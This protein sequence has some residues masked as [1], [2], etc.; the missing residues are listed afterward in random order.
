MDANTG[1]AIGNDISQGQDIARAMCYG[2]TY[3]IHVDVSFKLGDQPLPVE[4]VIFNGWQANELD[5]RENYQGHLIKLHEEIRTAN[6]E[7]CIP[8]DENPAPCGTDGS[9]IIQNDVL[10]G[11]SNEIDLGELTPEQQARYG[12]ISE[13]FAQLQTEQTSEGGDFYGG[14]FS[15]R[16]WFLNSE[17]EMN[18]AANTLTQ[19][20]KLDN[21]V[22]DYAFSYVWMG[23]KDARKTNGS[24]TFGRIFFTSLELTEESENLTEADQLNDITLKETIT[25]PGAF[26][27]A[28]WKFNFAGEYPPQSF[29]DFLNSVSYDTV[30]PT[31]W[32]NNS[33][34]DFNDQFGEPWPHPATANVTIANGL[35]IVKFYFVN[36]IGSGWD[37]DGIRDVFE[38]FGPSDQLFGWD[39]SIWG[40]GGYEEEVGVTLP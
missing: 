21:I 31:T 1:L 34:R 5:P 24:V 40:Q 39:S 32:Y 38:Y 23:N 7:V 18:Q 36:E 25:M 29:L 27:S 28:V 12:F 22:L 3:G 15:Y 26:T 10:A 35:P 11:G 33:W 16:G 8:S 14:D 30:D 20:E 17:D 19:G 9:V 4:N 37:K 2:R 13:F 6:D